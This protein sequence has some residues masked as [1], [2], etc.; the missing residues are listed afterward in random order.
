[1]EKVERGVRKCVEYARQINSD[2][3]KIEF[4]L[5]CVLVFDDMSETQHKELYLSKWKD[6]RD[7]D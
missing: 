3:G 2:G 1:M 5:A 6:C 4:E 7:C